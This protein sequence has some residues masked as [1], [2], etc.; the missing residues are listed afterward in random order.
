[1]FDSD[2]EQ[3]AKI[4]LETSLSVGAGGPPSTSSSW[5]CLANAEDEPAFCSAWLSLQ[6]SRIEGATTGV[7]V[8]QPSEKGAQRRVALW[9]A[10][11]HSDFVALSAMAERTLLQR[12]AISSQEVQK[13]PN[14][15]PAGH[16]LAVPLGAG[17]Q[18]IGAVAVRLAGV[19]MP[20]DLERLSDY[21]RWG[22]GWLE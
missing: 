8:L 21:L 10:P 4:H 2:P 7:L 1:M 19:L 14:G 22:A 16:L 15:Q 13:D 5:N 12:R 11:A 3:P 20:E 18:I 17:G 9:P 6:C